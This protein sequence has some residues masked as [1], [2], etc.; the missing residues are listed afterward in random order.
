MAYK[1]KIDG[2]ETDAEE[3]ATLLDEALKIGIRIPAICKHPGLGPIG[4]CRMCVVEIKKDDKSRLATSCNHVIREKDTGMEVF[5]DSERVISKRREVIEKMRSR[6][7]NVKLLKDLAAQCGAGEPGER[8]PDADLAFNACIHCGICARICDALGHH[9]ISLADRAAE[10][11]GKTPFCE[12][13]KDCV[14]CAACHRNCPT[15]A[16]EM[17]ETGSKRTIWNREFDLIPCSSCG[18]GLITREQAAFLRT[19]K[20]FSEAYF[21]KCD[22]CKRTDVAGTISR[23]SKW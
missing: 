15:G 5:T 4:S 20:G 23:I 22:A 3:G 9:A 1:I 12:A 10:K 11:T 13:S 17:N 8:H 6:W 7:P 21:D 16:I 19:S 18:R 2:K 14:G